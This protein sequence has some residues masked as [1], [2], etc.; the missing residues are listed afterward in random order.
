MIPLTIIMA[1][2]TTIITLFFNF[3]FNPLR[4]ETKN[5]Y[6]MSIQNFIKEVKKDFSDKPAKKKMKKPDNFE[7]SLDKVKV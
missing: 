3:L 4:T 1:F 6:A 2:L 5:T 7:R